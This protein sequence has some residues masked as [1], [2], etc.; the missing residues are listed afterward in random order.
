MAIAT[1]NLCYNNH[2]VF[3]GVVKIPQEETKQ[4]DLSKLTAK[5]FSFWKWFAAS[6]VLCLIIAF[7][8]LKFTLS[9]YE[10]TTSILLKDDQK[11]GGTAEIN[12]FKDM[13]LFTQKNNVDN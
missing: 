9:G 10:V 13:G 6:M 3:T 8:Y 2:N 12:A 1:L 7:I 5:Y 11:G 4:V